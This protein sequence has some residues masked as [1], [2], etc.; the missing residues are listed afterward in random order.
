MLVV[1]IFALGM[2]LAL[3]WFTGRRDLSNIVSPTDSIITGREES[4]PV[5][6]PPIEAPIAPTINELL[7]FL[8]SGST[9]LPRAFRFE[10]LNFILGTNNLMVGSDIE[11]GKIVGAMKEFPNTTA[12]I[13]GYTANIG[14][15]PENVELSNSRAAAIKERLIELGIAANRLEAVGMGSSKPIANNDTVEGRAQ[16]ERIEFVVTRIQ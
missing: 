11:L 14:T 12:R 6:E 2:F 16:N 7:P 9:E 15:E 1:T 8:Q 3:W 13:E 5:F 4:V 10:N